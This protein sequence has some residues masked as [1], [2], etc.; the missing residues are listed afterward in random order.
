MFSLTGERISL[1]LKD[2]FEVHRTKGLSTFQEKISIY[3]EHSND[4]EEINFINN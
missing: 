2:T 1:L 3:R 4:N